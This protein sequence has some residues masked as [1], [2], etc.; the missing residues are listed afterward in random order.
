MNYCSNS[1]YKPHS[2]NHIIDLGRIVNLRLRSALGETRM[3]VSVHKATVHR[4][5]AVLCKLMKGNNGFNSESVSEQ[6]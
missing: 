3:A 6:I 2:V 5:L 1:F 4:I